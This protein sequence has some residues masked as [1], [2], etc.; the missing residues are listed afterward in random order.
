M[1]FLDVFQKSFTAQT[2]G[3]WISSSMR[4]TPIYLPSYLYL[5]DKCVLKWKFQQQ[6]TK[7]FFLSIEIPLVLRLW[8]CVYVKDSVT[9]LG[10]ISSL[11]PNFKSLWLFLRAY[12]IFGK[13]LQLLWLIFLFF[14]ANFHSSQILNK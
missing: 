10:E 6:R 12:F 5:N 14:W 13:I 3:K 7:T 2:T 4:G 1:V 9:R 11:W 8:V